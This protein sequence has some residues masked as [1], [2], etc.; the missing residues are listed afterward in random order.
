MSI[1]CLILA[2]ICL[3]WAIVSDVNVKV[4]NE[5]CR[6]FNFTTLEANSYWGLAGIVIVITSVIFGLLNDFVV[7]GSANYRSFTSC[8][9]DAILGSGVLAAW[10]VWTSFSMSWI[11]ELATKL[12]V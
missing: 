3:I 5:L 8:S 2:Y 12:D 1:A 11:F 6:S 4:I 7:L 9:S 10:R